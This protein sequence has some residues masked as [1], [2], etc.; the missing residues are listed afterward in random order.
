[1]FNKGELE[2]SDKLLKE[3]Q[4]KKNAT[5]DAKKW[6]DLPNGKRYMSGTFAISIVHCKAPVLERCGQQ[7]RGGQNYWPSSDELNK[8]ILEWLVSNWSNISDDVIA[9]MEKKENEALKR[10]KAFVNQMS[11]LINN[12]DLKNE[13]E[14]KEN[15]K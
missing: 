15:G 8:A 1:M 13:A 5:A 2:M 11:E 14:L 10:C 4:A 6:N 3:W 7:Y 9:I 12:A